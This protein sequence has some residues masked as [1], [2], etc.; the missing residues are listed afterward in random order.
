[1]WLSIGVI[2]FKSL[3]AT[4]EERALEAANSGH[5]LDLT[6]YRIRGC[7]YLHTAM[8]PEHKKLLDKVIAE[9]GP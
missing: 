2:L 1:M 3:F 5:S 7:M 4:S 9:R 6:K 8:P